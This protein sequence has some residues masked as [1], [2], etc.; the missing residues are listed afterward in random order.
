MGGAIL[1]FLMMGCLPTWADTDNTSS[2]QTVEDLKGIDVSKLSDYVSDANPGDIGEKD[3]QKKWVMFYNVGQKKFLNMG[4]WWGTKPILSDVPRLFWLQQHTDKVGETTSA[5]EY[6]TYPTTTGT[7]VSI[8]PLGIMQ[9][10]TEGK[11]QIGS[12]QGAD[13]SN[14]VYNSVTLEKA[15]GTSREIFVKDAMGGGKSFIEN[16]NVDFAAGDKI[17][18]NVTLP[19]TTDNKSENV[20]SLGDGI[21]NWGK[22]EGNHNVHIFW[23]GNGVQYLE[24]DYVNAKF[25]ETDKMQIG[26]DKLN[27]EK[28]VV[29][30]FSKDGLNVQNDYSIVY[31]DAETIFPDETKANADKVALMMSKI[32]ENG[33]VQ[34]GSQ[35]GTNRSQATYNSVVLQ[36]KDGTQ[37]NLVSKGYQPGG[38]KFVKETAIDLEAGDKIV[39]DI[40]MPKTANNE[41]IIAFGTDVSQWNDGTKEN[42]Y[43]FQLYWNG[44]RIKTHYLYYN[45]PY[46]DKDYT[47]STHV[48]VEFSKNGLTIQDLNGTEEGVNETFFAPCVVN[49]DAA[50]S[51]NIKLKRGTS[52]DAS[53]YVVSDDGEAIAKKVTETKTYTEYVTDKTKQ[54]FIASNIVKSSNV[55]GHEGNFMAFVDMKD[56]GVGLN[57][58]SDLG[59]FVDR[60]INVDK[61]TQSQWNIESVDTTTGNCKLSLVMPYDIETGLAT[62]D[63]E[64]KTYFLCATSDYVKGYVNKV[65]KP[66]DDNKLWYESDPG[67]EGFKTD[68]STAKLVDASD[69]R[70]TSNNAVW[71]IIPLSAYVDM[72]NHKTEDLDKLLDITFLLKDAGFYRENGDLNAWKTSGDFAPSSDHNS[73]KLCIGY[74]GYYKTSTESTKYEVTKKEILLNARG[75]YMDVM[76]QNGGHG[77]FY[78]DIKVYRRG[79]YVI[80]CQGKSN[81]GAKLFVQR[82]D[83]TSSRVALSMKKLS[84]DEWARLSAGSPYANGQKW[85]YADGS[86][87]YNAC[88]EMNDRHLVKD[89]RTEYA[90]S[91][92]YYISQ[93]VSYDNPLT[94][95]IGIGIPENTEADGRT[96]FD[97]FR[98]QYGG[99]S[100]PILVL[101][102]NNSNL[103]SID[104][105]IHEY[106]NKTLFLKRS[107]KPGKWGTLMLPVNLNK[108]QFTEMFGEDA[109]LAYLKEIKG[110]V[111]RFYTVDD[112]DSVFLKAYMPYIIKVNVA[113]GSAP[114]FTQELT[115]RNVDG[116]AQTQTLKQVVPDDCFIVDGVTLVNHQDEKDHYYDFKGGKFAQD[117]QSSVYSTK[118]DN[119]DYC[120][121][122]S[123]VGNGAATNSQDGCTLISYGTLCKTYHIESDGPHFYDNRPNLK[124]GSSYY[125][126]D[127]TMY[128][129]TPTKKKDGTEVDYGYG[130]LGFRCWFVYDGGT[131]GYAK[132]AQLSVTFKGIDETT[133]IDE[134]AANDGEPVVKR[135]ANAVYN[136]SGQ[137]V[138]HDLQSLNTL[139]AGMYIVN[140][141]KYVVNK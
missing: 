41:N 12:V 71:R 97:T 120:V 9:D 74:D 89:K 30:T 119:Y 61:Q 28:P 134:I 110:N 37:T 101:N 13:R 99:K 63:K 51:G 102:E 109:L 104:N 50:K 138:S 20:L 54:T 79:W 91:V 75:R 77:E 127:N 8:S 118:A 35:E 85:P 32:Q 72:L 141:K 18:A 16:V 11:F 136:M 46:P 22:D 108:R 56:A 76:V 14:A 62:E 112:N 128:R 7:S 98:I 57:V 21:V 78:Q 130:L 24:A 95:R 48:K 19:G 45:G 59:V 4:G 53:Y 87:M 93:D 114:G 86:P 10:L 92:K 29:F 27:L 15:N 90:N 96:I 5:S 124:G 107:F 73:D 137:L 125:F 43:S 26:V 60:A 17:I 129:H 58:E 25:T 2:A 82:G 55:G 113:K 83:N 116:Q 36:K 47:C 80:Q 42:V 121:K 64:N 65:D 39:A 100:D 70:V 123:T 140:G 38:E 3:S 66:S 106:K 94:L 33:K 84:A 105:C 69:D 111:V 68:L 44:S 1:A 126:S 49:Y 88:V 133:D 34:V 122:A 103:D 81:V 23:G 31:K 6:Y 139:P 115:L 117:A 52:T 132:P 67:K 131:Q 40:T 135:Y